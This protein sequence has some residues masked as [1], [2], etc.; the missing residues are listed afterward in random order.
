MGGSA[1]PSINWSSIFG[2]LPA[3]PTIRAAGTAYTP[4]ALPSGIGTGARPAWQPWSPESWLTAEVPGAFKPT[5]NQATLDSILAGVPGAMDVSGMRGRAQTALEDHL[6]RF[7]LPQILESMGATGN[8]YST[9]ANQAVADAAAK[10]QLSLEELFAPIEA[11]AYEGYAGREM[12]RRNLEFELEKLTQT[13]MSQGYEAAAAREMARRQLGAQLTTTGW[14]EARQGYDAAGS[15]EVALQQLLGDL[16][17]KREGLALAGQEGQANREQQA[18]LAQVE[19]YKEQ[20]AYS[21]AAA[22]VRAQSETALSLGQIENARAL[23]V[24]AG[25]LE[26]AAKERQSR[27]D[28]GMLTTGLSL[29]QAANPSDVQTGDM[30]AKFTAANQPIYNQIVRAAPVSY[31]TEESSVNDVLASLLQSIG[32]GGSILPQL[33]GGPGQT[34]VIGGVA[35]ILAQLLGGKSASTPGVGGTIGSVSNL[36][37]VVKSVWD[38]IFGGDSGVGDAW[39]DDILDSTDFATGLGTE[40]TDWLSGIF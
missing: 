8:R 34:G 38:S 20:M 30:L 25:Q 17:G 26:D 7:V 19:I 15:R 24:A 36:G 1:A 11:A 16:W 32:L 33:F 9:S 4:S 28:M 39:W 22:Q 37:S 12:V 40:N 13:L 3:A 14:S 23:A 10:Q 27:L 35:D 6:K 2:A 29:Y 18:A 5:T 21:R 31:E